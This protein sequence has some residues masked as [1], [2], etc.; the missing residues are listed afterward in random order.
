ML[1]DVKIE[2]YVGHVSGGI[3]RFS[4]GQTVCDPRIRRNPP[5]TWPTYFS[6]LNGSRRGR[7]VSTVTYVSVL[8]II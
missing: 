5:E 7:P 3:L 6:M 1:S 8:T 4:H 2:K